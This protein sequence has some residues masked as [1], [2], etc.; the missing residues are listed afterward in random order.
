[1][2]FVLISCAS[3]GFHLAPRG[4][5]KHERGANNSNPTTSMPDARIESCKQVSRLFHDRTGMHLYLIG[6]SKVEFRICLFHKGEANLHCID[7]LPNGSNNKD[8]MARKVDQKLLMRN[9]YWSSFH[10]VF[11]AD[12]HF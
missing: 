3:N 2:T 7:S 10:M 6:K 8:Q 1:M 4:S 11:T 9:G 5:M 12:R